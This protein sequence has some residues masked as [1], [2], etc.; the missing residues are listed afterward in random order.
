MRIRVTKIFLTTLV[1]GFVFLLSACKPTPTNKGPNYAIITLRFSSSAFQESNIDSYR[2]Q[3]RAI[4]LFGNKD[5][6]GRQTNWSDVTETEKGSGVVNLPKIQTGSWA[7]YARVSDK[8][9]TFIDIYTG[10]ITVNNDYTI[11]INEDDQDLTGYDEQQ[12]YIR[13]DY[14]FEKQTLS[15][16][17]ED[18]RSGA[19]YQADQ[20][21]IEVIKNN[22]SSVDYYLSSGMLPAGNYAVTVKILGDGGTVLMSKMQTV[23]LRS[24]GTD[25]LIMRLTAEA[26]VPG[27]VTI[28]GGEVLEG[29]LK[30]DIENV[31]D[32]VCTYHFYP[33]NDYTK[34][35]AV[36]FYWYADG[37]RY[38]TKETS[39]EITFPYPGEYVISCTPIG[40]NGEVMKNG[41]ASTNTKIT[42]GDTSEI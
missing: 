30:G 28:I 22:R 7:I 13:A 39:I 6:V 9:K 17:Y 15:V 21:D 29:F 19:I 40:I 31:K 2:I 33:L 11:V 12:I 14:V 34:E 16:E 37:V 8:S 38:S 5:T 27:S 4:P 42:L 10:P 32:A 36:W 23:E 1:M 41:V 24:T 35:N 25:A 20:T 3:Y 18:T 26:A